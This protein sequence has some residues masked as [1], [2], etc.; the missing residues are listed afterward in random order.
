MVFLR[1]PIQLP[2][3]AYS[4]KFYETELVG[5]FRFKSDLPAHRFVQCLLVSL[6]QSKDCP[7]LAG[8]F[9]VL[10]DHSPRNWSHLQQFVSLVLSSHKISLCSLCFNVF[11]ENYLFFCFYVYLVVSEVWSHEWRSF[12]PFCILIESGIPLCFQGA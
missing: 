11:K 4:V 10:P 5:S 6:C 8:G 2:V 7:S 9:P 1:L 3:S 12:I